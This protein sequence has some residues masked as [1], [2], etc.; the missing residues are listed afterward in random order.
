MFILLSEDTDQYYFLEPCMCI[1]QWYSF[2]FIVVCVGKYGDIAK[3]PSF[4]RKKG[5]EVFKGKVLHTLDYCKLDK[6]AA[7]Q[8]LKDKKVA[9]IGFKKSAIDL[10]MECALANQGKYLNSTLKSLNRL[11]ASYCIFLFETLLAINVTLSM[12]D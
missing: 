4:P 2:E 5:P 1:F 6:E 12:K 10:A 7:T 9:V 8:L 3:I 11:L